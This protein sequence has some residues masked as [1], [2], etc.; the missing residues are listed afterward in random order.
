MKFNMNSFHSKL[1]RYF[2]FGA[3]LGPFEF[4]SCHLLISSCELVKHMLVA[5]CLA[6]FMKDFNNHTSLFTSNKQFYL[7]QGKSSW[8]RVGYTLIL[9][10]QA[11]N[12]LENYQFF[13]RSWR[14]TGGSLILK[15]FRK[16][17]LEVV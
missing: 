12:L 17:K 16:A 2:E 15:Y 7:F 6:N 5:P 14:G 8:V 1:R 13:A 11:K 3:L 4:F 10:N 9:K